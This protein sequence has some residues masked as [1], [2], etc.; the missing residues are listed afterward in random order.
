MGRPGIAVESFGHIDYDGALTFLAN[1][2][3]SG[4]RSIGAETQE[5]L[6]QTMSS[7]KVRTRDPSSVVEDI[8]ARRDYLRERRTWPSPRC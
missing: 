8:K 6:Y 7:R 4:E 5:I 2:Y 3:A 1:G